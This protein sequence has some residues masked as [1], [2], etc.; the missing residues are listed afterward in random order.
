MLKFLN[1]FDVQTAQEESDVEHFYLSECA[2]RD[3]GELSASSPN[4]GKEFFNSVTDVVLAG[5][6]TIPGSGPILLG[7]WKEM[8]DNCGARTLGDV[9]IGGILYARFGGRLDTG[10]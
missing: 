4:G 8:L 6:E 1:H 7:E 2:H 5:C 9:G 3:G 10:F